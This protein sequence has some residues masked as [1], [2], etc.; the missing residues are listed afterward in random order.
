MGTEKKLTEVAGV[1]FEA[2]TRLGMR[3]GGGLSTDHVCYTLTKDGDGR[4]YL[5]PRFVALQ[6]PKFP[7]ILQGII[8]VALLI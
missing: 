7:Y 2:R 3:N 8:T 6:A 4:Q 5:L 1:C